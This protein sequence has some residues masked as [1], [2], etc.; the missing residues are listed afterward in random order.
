MSVERYSQINANI[1]S[2]PDNLRG[3]TAGRNG[4]FAVGKAQTEVAC[5]IFNRRDDI[6]VIGQWFAHAH[7]NDIFDVRASGQFMFQSQDLS[8]NFRRIQVPLKALARR[9]TEFTVHGASGLGGYADRPVVFPRDENAFNK[10][11]VF[12]T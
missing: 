3:K 11:S 9:Q 1:F 5:D 4:H 7:H 10:P 6:V 2:Q 8:R 12:Q